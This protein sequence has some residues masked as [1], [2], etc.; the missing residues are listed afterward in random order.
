MEILVDVLQ[1]FQSGLDWLLNTTGWSKQQLKKNFKIAKSLIQLGIVVWTLY[2]LYKLFRAGEKIYVDTDKL[3]FKIPL[4]IIKFIF[5]LA[6]LLVVIYSND[7]ECP[8]C[9]CTSSQTKSTNSYLTNSCT[10][11]KN[12]HIHLYDYDGNP[13]K[14]YYQNV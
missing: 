3:V 12:S 7:E 1:T 4:T 6:V 11:R 8:P 2:K 5:A 14:F 9:N 13:N 10:P